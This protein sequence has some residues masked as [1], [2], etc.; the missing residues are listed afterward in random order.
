MKRGYI[1]L[2]LASLALAGCAANGESH[3]VASTAPAH[4]EARAYDASAEAK[5]DVDAAL[6]RAA[7]SGKLVLLAMGANWC[8]DSRA[9]AG[10]METP[11]FRN[12]IADK[13]EL[14]YVNVGM[15]Q[16]KDGHNLDIAERL[17]VEVK[18]TPTIVII[19][20]EN[21]VLNAETAAGWRNAA[22]R[23]EDE[24]FNE[25]ASYHA[26]AG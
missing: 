26:A 17:G 23:S 10:W 4:P 25:L 16:S 6:Q 11:R 7:A 2:A 3:S 13:Y 21:G 18:G 8:H 22:S 20:P 12:L 1:A 5:G 14:V 15:P 19:S 24:I 9:F